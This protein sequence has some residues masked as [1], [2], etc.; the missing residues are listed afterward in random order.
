MGVPSVL[1]EVYFDPLWMNYNLG[2]SKITETHLSKGPIEAKG[3]G[4]LIQ[5]DGPQFVADELLEM[6]G[7]LRHIDGSRL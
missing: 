5:R 6:L 1:S 4:H 3:H 7:K 2:L